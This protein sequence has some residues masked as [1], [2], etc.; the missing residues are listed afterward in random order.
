MVQHFSIN[1][2]ERKI[3]RNFQTNVGHDNRFWENHLYA[4]WADGRATRLSTFLA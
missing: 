4:A 3:M 1:D 2:T